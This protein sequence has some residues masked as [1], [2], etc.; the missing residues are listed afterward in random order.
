MCSDNIVGIRTF[1]LVSTRW[2]LHPVLFCGL[3]FAIASYV[4]VGQRE[5][6]VEHAME[7]TLNDFGVHAFPS[8]GSIIRFMAARKVACRMNKM[9]IPITHPISPFHTP[10]AHHH[11]AIPITLTNHRCIALVPSLLPGPYQLPCVVPMGNTHDPV[12]STPL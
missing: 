1:G 5:M 7:Y 2:L 4:G 6:V 8:Y 10:L 11:K 12:A 9:P 3:N